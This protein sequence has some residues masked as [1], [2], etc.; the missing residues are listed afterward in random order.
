MIWFEFNL[1]FIKFYIDCTLQYYSV[2]K[3]EHVFADQQY[4]E[5]WNFILWR[6]ESE[7]HDVCKIRRSTARNS[8]QFWF[9][10]IWVHCFSMDTM[11]R[12]L[13]D[14]V[15][16]AIHYWIYLVASTFNYIPVY[17]RHIELYRQSTNNKIKWNKKYIRNCWSW[18]WKKS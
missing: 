2:C 13:I 10:I 14:V 12:M 16:P 15:T 7:N 6:R 4:F 5:I 18:S 9:H 3:L 11:L 1:V 17:V 8:P